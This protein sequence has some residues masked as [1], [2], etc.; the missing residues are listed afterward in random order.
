M[1][2]GAPAFAID[3][4]PHEALDMA[5]ANHGQRLRHAVGVFHQVVR[6][7]TGLDDL[8]AAGIERE[9]LCLAG[10]QTLMETLR[11]AEPTAGGGQA[12]FALSAEMVLVDGGGQRVPVQLSSGERC[13]SLLA[14]LDRSA[15]PGDPWLGRWLIPRH[16]RTLEAH[17]VAGRYLLWVHIRDADDEKRVCT[18]L[19]RH[20]EFPVQVHDLAL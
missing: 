1:C 20:S 11:Q 18:I 4:E 12:F 15:T 16:A 14:T 19:L 3:A 10:Q 8:I 2:L 7:R 13:A 17:L 5:G 9:A 6:L